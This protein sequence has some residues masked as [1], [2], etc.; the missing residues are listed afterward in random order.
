MRAYKLELGS[1][2]A[3]IFIL[4]GCGG[5]NASSSPSPVAVMPVPE[6]TPVTV[7]PPP[8]PEDTGEAEAP[9]RNILEAM[10]QVTA[11]VEKDSENTLAASPLSGVAAKGVMG[12]ARLIVFD[13]LTPPEDV[14]KDGAGL[15]GQGVTN[16]DGTYSLSVQTT[17]QTSDY[18]VVGAFFKDAT[19]VCDAPSGCFKGVAYGETLTLGESD[20][21]LW[22]VFPTPAPGATAT[23]NINLFTHFQLFRMLGFAYDEQIETDEA[24]EPITLQAQHF[25]PAFEYVSNAFGIQTDSFHTI[26]YVDPTQPID[27]SNLDAI[28]MGLL[29]AGFLEAEVQSEIFKDGEEAKFDEVLSGAAIPFLIPDLL[30][31]LNENDENNNPRIVSLEDMFEAALKTAELNTTNNNSLSLAIDFLTEQNALI[32]TLTFDARLKADGT[33]PEERRPVEEPEPEP[34]PDDGPDLDPDEGYTGPTDNPTCE[35]NLSPNP[36]DQ[37]VLLS[38]YEGTALSSVAVTSLDRDTEVTRVRIEPGETP[39]YIIAST[40]EDMLWSIEGD[41]SRVAGFV[42]ANGQRSGFEG[43][44]VVGL[45]QDKVDFIDYACMAYFTSTSSKAARKAETKFERIF[46]REIDHLIS[47]YTLSSVAIPSGEMIDRTTRNEIETAAIAAGET[48]ITADNGI[49]FSIESQ[50][51]YAD[52]TQLFRFNQE[53]LATVPVKQVVSSGEVQTYDVFPA[54]A[55]LVQLLS[56]G[57]IE[58][59]GRDNGYLHS[60]FIHETFPRFPAGLTGGISVKFILG[61]G[62]EMP[63]GDAGHSRIYSDE[64]GECLSYLC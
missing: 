36:T 12:G 34:N 56:S 10:S 21:A 37:I 61:S 59:L 8:G 46:E 41:T 62:V 38:G 2:L 39:L 19:M 32:D 29:S 7:T 53:G 45:T 51:E 6:P 22:A 42:A 58:Y 35:P 16:S 43:A 27:S 55:G 1:A 63:G 49:K 3:A 30:L 24:E 44:G 26:P 5:S 18:L 48:Q 31:T 9:A 14:G 11:P 20:Q 13:A 28:K 57:H 15:L 60:Y 4:T 64:T 33:Y 54:H 40:L 17:E 50:T 23:A 47:D 52:Q 25:R